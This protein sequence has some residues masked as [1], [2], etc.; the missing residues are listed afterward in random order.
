M[1]AKNRDS[2]RS[3][4]E[5][6]PIPDNLRTQLTNLKVLDQESQLVGEVKDLHRKPNGEI[7]LVV[8]GSEPSQGSPFFFI[9]SQFVQRVDNAA[10]CL[11]INLSTE[12]IQEL[13]RVQPTTG[14]ESVTI[15]A[16]PN[17]Q[18]EVREPSALLEAQAIEE[19]DPNL[20]RLLGERLVVDRHRRKIG[21]VIVR[22]EIET[23]MVQVPV[24]REKLI[25]EQVGPEPRRLAEVD[26]SSPEITGLELQQRANP[27]T[28]ATV[29]AEFNSVQRASQ[30]LK[31]VATQPHHG[32]VKVRLEL[33]LEDSQHQETY[34]KW[35]N[36]YSD[37]RSDTE[38]LS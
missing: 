32:C 18:I 38:P 12:Q 29:S 25:I 15:P 28:Q 11:W 14:N 21:E 34:Q 17:T 10:H 20:I 9:N 33:V 8:A 36:R 37:V 19:G 6:D 30:L 7:D 13:R 3:D 22:K 26:L 5:V 2:R 24:R 35:L 27:D 1:P 31:A 16:V 23:R 4:A